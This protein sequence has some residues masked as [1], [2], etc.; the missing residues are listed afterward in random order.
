VTDL[1]EQPEGD[2]EVEEPV[3]L[4]P[5]DYSDSSRDRPI[6]PSTPSPQNTVNTVRWQIGMLRVKLVGKGAI[7]WKERRRVVSVRLIPLWLK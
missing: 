7:L 5:P 4:P 6:K 1:P 2:E 3:L